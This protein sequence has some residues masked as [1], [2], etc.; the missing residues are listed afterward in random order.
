MKPYDTI[1]YILLFYW[2]AL[3]LVF[4]LYIFFAVASIMFCYAGM[5]GTLAYHIKM[6]GEIK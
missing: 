2:F 4:D 6:H 1:Y 5:M 3:I